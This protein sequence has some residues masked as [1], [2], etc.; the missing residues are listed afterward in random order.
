MSHGNQAQDPEGPRDGVL[1][2][3]TGLAEAELRGILRELRHIR[4]RSDS[5]IA[6]LEG[7]LGERKPKREAEPEKT[8]HALTAEILDRLL[9]VHVPMAPARRPQ[10]LRAWAKDIEQIP[11][12]PARIRETL[13]WLFSEENREAKYSFV[14]HSGHALRQKYSRI[15]AQIDRPKPQ[16]E[17][18]EVLR[19]ARARREGRGTRSAVPTLPFG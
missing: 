4:T 3:G 19:E 15:R 14:V 13:Y 12:S 1:A 7:A 17:I 10:S 8:E 6:Q 11:D 9:R 5:L 18:E 16:D 2:A